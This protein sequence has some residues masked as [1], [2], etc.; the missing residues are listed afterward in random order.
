M[1]DRTRAA[2]AWLL[3]LGTL[4]AELTFLIYLC[5]GRW[6]QRLGFAVQVVAVYSLALGLLVRREL[7]PVGQ[8][9]VDRMTSADPLAFYSGNFLVFALAFATAATGFGKWRRAGSSLAL[10]CVGQLLLLP[11]L[12]ILLASAALHILVFVPLVCPCYLLASAI[13]ESIRGSTEEVTLDVTDPEEPPESEEYIGTSETPADSGAMM[14]STVRLAQ[15]Q[16]YLVKSF[17]VGLPAVALVF[18]VKL[19][20]LLMAQ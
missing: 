19:I 17:L 9:I 1:G 11:A 4:A 13:V 6:D 12:P 14:A 16:P 3:L 7:G 20:P 18:V 5:G 15:E 10:G 8:D 2:C